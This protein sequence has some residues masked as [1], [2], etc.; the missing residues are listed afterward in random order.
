M[1][2]VK[3]VSEQAEKSIV[4]LAARIRQLIREDYKGELRVII[5]GRVKG[6]HLY[7]YESEETMRCVVGI[8]EES[9]S[10]VSDR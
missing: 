2:R 6:I 3:Q 7:G 1:K 9:L 5:N 10:S 4:V 8:C